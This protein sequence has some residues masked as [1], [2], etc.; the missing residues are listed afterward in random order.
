MPTPEL[1]DLEAVALAFIHRNQPCT[2]YAVR[3]CLQ[4]SPAA[5]FSDSAGSIYPLVRRLE[6]RGLLRSAAASTGA[7]RSRVYTATAAGV[8]A[9]K[10]WL[11]L[12]NNPAELATSDPLR[13]RA[14]YLD[15]LPEKD[16]YAW[17]ERAK[18]LLEAHQRAVEAFAA[19]TDDDPYMALAN[20]NARRTTR[21][22]IEWLNSVRRGFV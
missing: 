17:C 21:A 4:A 11:R 14:V 15:M 19:R 7:R 1:T 2:P 8:R 22:R 13:T 9:V 3:R 18:Q 20:D 12:P 6:R 16:R 10:A 5:R